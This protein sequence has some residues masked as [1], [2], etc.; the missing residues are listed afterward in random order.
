MSHAPNS[1]IQKFFEEYQKSI[2]QGPQIAA[3]QYAD[4]I[5]I[6]TPKGAYT[7][8]NEDFIKMLPGRKDF[9]DKTGLKS[10]HIVSLEEMSDDQFYCIIKAIWSFE[11]KKDGSE[12]KNIQVP[13]TYILRKEKDSF[14]IIFQLDHEDLI[15]KSKL[16]S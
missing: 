14:K 9:F 8:K 10:S 7:F 15:E 5:M 1:Q 2:E 3:A 12:A 6:A 16:T 13:T 4:P 11:F